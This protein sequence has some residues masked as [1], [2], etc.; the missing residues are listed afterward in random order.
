MLGSP[1]QLRDPG[2]DARA[3]PPLASPPKLGEHAHEILSSLLGMA[4]DEIAALREAGV[5]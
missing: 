5:I 4:D 1:I 3:L 2:S